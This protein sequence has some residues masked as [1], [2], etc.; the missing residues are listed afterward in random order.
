M[1]LEL[2]RSDF[3]K[4]WQVVEKYTPSKT[5]LDALYCIRLTASGTDSLILEAT[6]LK[7]SVRFTAKGAN[8]IDH[9]RK[10][11]TQSRQKHPAIHS[12]ARRHIP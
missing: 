4:A 10:R 2:D 1:K 8:V 12:P 9:R 6:D 3:L 7:S 11:H 5:T